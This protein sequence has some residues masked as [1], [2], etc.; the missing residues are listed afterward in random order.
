MERHMSKSGYCAKCNEP[1][2]EPGETPLCAYHRDHPQE[3]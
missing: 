2:D 3:D 1:S